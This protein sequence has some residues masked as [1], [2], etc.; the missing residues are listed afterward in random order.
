MNKRGLESGSQS[1]G[2]CLDAVLVLPKD[3]DAA[4]DPWHSHLHT[5]P[6]VID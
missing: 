6:A 4:V 2:L 3:T 1:S 5:A